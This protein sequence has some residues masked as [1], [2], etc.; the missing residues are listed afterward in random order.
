[1]ELFINFSQLYDVFTFD[2]SSVA[3]F[4][5]TFDLLTEYKQS[6]IYPHDENLFI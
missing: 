6:V 3:T 5:Y 4:A 1:M 2:L